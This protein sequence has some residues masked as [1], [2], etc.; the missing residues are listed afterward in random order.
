[1]LRF[2]GRHYHL[3]GAHG[4]PTPAS[5]I[6]IWIGAYGPRALA[7]TARVADGW[8][9]S[10]RGDL[11]AIAE[12]ARRLEDEAAAAG[13]EPAELR[14][15][16]NVSGTITAGE[17]G[18]PLRGPVDQWVDELGDLAVGYGFDTFVFW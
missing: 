9:P 15:I 18:G 6:G 10:F 16:L 14:R 5:P 17:T 8:V 11:G 2:D 4:G 1:N 3:A 7:L 12:M 13:R